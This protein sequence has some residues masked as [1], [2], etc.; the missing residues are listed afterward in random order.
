[1]DIT[2]TV[3]GRTLA[4]EM[5]AA[6]TVEDLPD[7]DAEALIAQGVAVPRT[8]APAA[9]ASAPPEAPAAGADHGPAED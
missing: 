9:P 8:A 1:M 6:G 2:W 7:A 3:G 5:R 4:G